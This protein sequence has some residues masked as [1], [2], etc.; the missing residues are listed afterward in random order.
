MRKNKLYTPKTMRKDVFYAY[1]EKN[2]IVSRSADLSSVKK[3][4]RLIH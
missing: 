1:Y 3:V 2:K 4:Q